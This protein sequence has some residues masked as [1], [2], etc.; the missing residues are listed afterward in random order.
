VTRVS[1]KV[2]VSVDALGKVTAAEG[3]VEAPTSPGALSEFAR[4]A[5]VDAARRWRFEPAQV[6]GH[7]VPGS[8][9]IHF[10]FGHATGSETRVRR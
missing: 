2:T 7:A 5:A 1:V 8:C 6:N 10:E 3:T 9:V 4:R